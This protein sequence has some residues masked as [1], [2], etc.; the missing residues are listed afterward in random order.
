MYSIMC[1]IRKQTFIYIYIFILLCVQEAVN[2]SICSC[3]KLE[4][5]LRYNIIRTHISVTNL[6]IIIFL[7]PYYLIDCIDCM[8]IAVFCITY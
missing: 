4:Q 8:I 1:S 7:I 5:T 2:F 3:L 6:I